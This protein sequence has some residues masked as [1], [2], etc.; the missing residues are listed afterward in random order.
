MADNLPAGGRRLRADG[1][2]HSDPDDERNDDG[3][4]EERKPHV[5]AET[6]PTPIR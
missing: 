6:T 3:G 4:E 1:K 2:C 5:S